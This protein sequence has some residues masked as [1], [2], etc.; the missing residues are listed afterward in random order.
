MIENFN[1]AKMQVPNYFKI[2]VQNV[3]YSSNL[4]QKSH[5]FT[6]TATIEKTTVKHGNNDHGYNKL[7]A[8]TI[9]WS[10]MVILVH[11]SPVMTVT[12]IGTNIDGTIK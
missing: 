11:N 1:L 12:V 3:F 8:V 5:F 4:T 2:N 9:F 6:A 7:K 10:Q